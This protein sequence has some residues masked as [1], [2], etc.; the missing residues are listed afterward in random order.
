[1]VVVLVALLACVVAW[2]AAVVIGR[3]PAG[4]GALP[5]ELPGEA[6]VHL[7]DG[8]LH[9]EDVRGLRLPTAIRGYRMAEVD[10]MLRR[11]AEELEARDAALAEMRQHRGADL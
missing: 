10:D 5:P 3:L 7:P 8:P 11:M 4:E 9:G 2:V 1:M 6:A